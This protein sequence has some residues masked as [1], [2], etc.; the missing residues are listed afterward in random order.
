VGCRRCACPISHLFVV[1]KRGTLN[2]REPFFDITGV[3]RTF[4]SFGNAKLADWPRQEVEENAATLLQLDLTFRAG[5]NAKL[6]RYGLE[7]SAAGLKGFLWDTKEAPGV[8]TPVRAAHCHER[9]CEE[10]CSPCVVKEVLKRTKFLKLAFD[11]DCS[12]HLKKK[13]SGLFLWT[14]H[15]AGVHDSLG[16]NAVS[17][18]V[19]RVLQ[20]AGVSKDW[21]TH[22]LR[23]LSPSKAINMGWP[24][25]ASLLR[26][27]WSASSDT[28]EKSY[29]RRT[30]YKET[31]PDNAKLPFEVVI[32]LNE[33]RLL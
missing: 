22:L 29:Y 13:T 15:R 12:P 24:W 10:W 8:L 33:T 28:F 9:F 26:G 21:T 2:R 17:N 5:E 27:R 4:G 16:S 3:L 23:G 25:L 1:Q 30:L 31:S 32:R 14:H 18:K 19:K 11:I 7:V 20:R 6:I